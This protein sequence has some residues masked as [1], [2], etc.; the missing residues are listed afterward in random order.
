P[1]G[2]MPLG[3]PK[4]KGIVP[5][6]AD[7]SPVVDSYNK[8]VRIRMRNN[9]VIN[10]K[11]GNETMESQVLAENIQSIINFLEDTLEKG[12]HNI[13]KISIKMTMG[14]AVRVEGLLR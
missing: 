12:L 7:L 14:A 2:K 6:N 8:M 9:L 13:A 3:P 5:P 11:V 4:G 1:A 10:C